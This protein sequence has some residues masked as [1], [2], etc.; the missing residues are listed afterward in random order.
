MS[1]P[2]LDE[3][4]SE[5]QHARETA[6]SEL[7][8][9]ILNVTE[10]IDRL[11]DREDDPRPD[12]LESIHEE[13]ERLEDNTEGE[14]NDHLTQAREHVRAYHDNLDVLADEDEL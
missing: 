1:D 11:D 9:P 10:S 13:L 8:D 12:R 3:I 2:D 14:A 7:N 4:R 5:L 6:K